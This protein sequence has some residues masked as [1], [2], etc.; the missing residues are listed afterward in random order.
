MY[1]K[2]PVSKSQVRLKK[3]I[4]LNILII[5]AASLPE[6]KLPHS[7]AAGI[8]AAAPVEGLLQ[9]TTQSLEKQRKTHESSWAQ[10][11]FYPGTG[12]VLADDLITIFYTVS[13]LSS[14][15]DQYNIF[16]KQFYF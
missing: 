14:T 1:F 11:S 6:E 2:K 10:L 8:Q 5:S 13:L 7:S 9:V 4:N 15:S 3:K 12:D 16:S